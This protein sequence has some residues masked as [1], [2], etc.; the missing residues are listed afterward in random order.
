[1]EWTQAGFKAARDWTGTAQRAKKGILKSDLDKV[2]YRYFEAYEKTCL[3][4]Y[5]EESRI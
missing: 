5:E 4:R 3:E 2:T 1:M